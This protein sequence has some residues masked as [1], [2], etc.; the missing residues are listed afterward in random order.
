LI[1]AFQFVSVSVF[2]LL[3]ERVVGFLD[4]LIQQEAA[5][6]TEGVEAKAETLNRLRAKATARQERRTADYAD[7]TDSKLKDV[8]SRRHHP[9]HPRN[10]RLKTSVSSVISCSNLQPVAS[11]G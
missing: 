10:L 4:Q 8:H 7:N 1:S 3:L 5:E 2:G 6:R 11:A 9:L